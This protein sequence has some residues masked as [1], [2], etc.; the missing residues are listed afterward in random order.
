[1]KRLQLI[2]RWLQYRIYACFLWLH[3]LERMATYTWTVIVFNVF[4][5]VLLQ[6]ADFGMSRDLFDEDYYVMSSGGKVPLKWTAPESLYYS[7]YSTA[8]DVWS[9][10]CLLYEI[11][12]LGT[13][14][15]AK[16]TNEDVSIV[17]SPMVHSYFIFFAISFPV[18]RVCRVRQ[19]TISTSWMP[20]GNI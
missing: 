18:H 4:D 6:V 10:G 2:E 8:S 19:K 5:S 13:K 9:Y 11:W 7:K 14:P 1:M 16:I 17:C 20:Q 12:S 3:N 15:Y